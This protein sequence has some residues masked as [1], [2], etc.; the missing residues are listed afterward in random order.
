MQTGE[1]I[2][3]INQ[4]AP[5]ILFVYNRPVHTK[6]VLDALAL[7]PQ[8]G[9]C[10]LYVFCDGEKPGS[11][12]L[13]K[14]N[15]NETRTIVKSENRF[16]EVIVTEQNS[17]LGLSGSIITGVTQVITKHGKAIV[18]EDDIVAEKG[19]LQ[20]MNQALKMYSNNDQVG[21]I[22]AWNYNL[23]AASYNESTF[24]LRGADCWGWATW[25]RAWDLF[26]ADGSQLLAEIRFAGADYEFDRKA[27]HPFLEMLVNQV[28]GKVDSWAIRWHASLF[29]AGKFCLHPTR[30]IV[31]N[32]GLDNS[33]I[34]C[35]E[36]DLEQETSEFIDLKKIPVQES[37]WFFLAFNNS[38][39][40]HISTGQTSAQKIKSFL[41]SNLPSGMIS[42]I[43]KLRGS[44]NEGWKGEYR[45]WQDAKKN[46]VGYN[47]SVILD[48]CKN[49]L[50]KVKN[51]EA[52]FE[53][54]GVTFD[55]PDN[56]TTVSHLLKKIAA[57]NNGCLTVLDFGGSLGS[58]YYL[59]K[60]FLDTVHTLAWCVVEQKNFVDCGKS[61]FEDHRLKFYYSI[62]ECMN[63]HKPSVLILSS[64]LQYLEEPSAW[65]QKFFSLGIKYIIIDRTPFLPA[66]EKDI[67]T[68]QTVPPTI[69][70][71]SYPAWFFGTERLKQLKNGYKIIAKF[72]N[73]ITP[74][75]TINNNHKAYWL[76]LVLQK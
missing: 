55:K 74:P 48:K 18:L 1:T 29:I 70:Q 69:Y 63:L 36:M 47:S 38:S 53:R 62:E 72:D 6:I 9:D 28:K 58:S 32:I 44:N 14:S 4:P 30:A 16:K 3:D 17:N 20:Y 76:G 52:L 64:V 61:F 39:N 60:Q 35:V 23:N 8:S 50:L 43:K 27:T 37:E 40:K 34:H 11:S 26:I 31:K 65:I 5:I 19:F 25:K 51:G 22:H 57:E 33:G 21:C 42:T 73:G 68:I 49:A 7:N 24:F 59:N 13:T 15:I 2:T 46:C 56:N 12:E 45:T 54:D 10:T 75:A 41:K 66:E 71:A 67:L